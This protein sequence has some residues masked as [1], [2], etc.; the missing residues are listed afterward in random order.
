MKH[1][2]DHHLEAIWKGAMILTVAGIL[3]KVLSAAYRVP[4]QNI[5]GDVGFYIYQQVYPFYG[6]AI[7]L[8]TYGFPVVISKLIAEHP[9]VNKTEAAKKIGTI[10]FV[11][12]LFLGGLLFLVLYFGADAMAGMMGDS[13]LTQLIGIV[14]FS[15]LLMP[16]LSV[17]RG[18]FQGRG[19]MTPTAV[20]QVSEQLIRVCTILVLSYLLVKQGHSLYEVGAGA[21]VGSVGGGLAAVA[22]LFFFYQRHQAMVK[23]QKNPPVFFSTGSIVK[24]LVLQGFTICISSLLLVLFQMVDSF[25]VY[26]YL[27]ENGSSPD[28]AKLL[29]GI[30]DRGQPLIQ[31]GTVVATAFSLSLVPY[32]TRA[33]THGSLSEMKDKMMISIRVSIAIGAAA[34]VGLAWLIRPVNTMLFSNGNGSGVLLVLGFSILFCSI[35]LT[36][37]A[38]LQGLGHA[39]LPAFYVLAGVLVKILLNVAFI[40]GFQTMGAALS[41]LLASF[42]VASGLLLEIKRK[43][44]ITI[45]EKAY[46]YP[47]LVSIALMSATLAVFLEGSLALVGSSRLLASAQSLIGVMLGGIVFL[48]VLIK[49]N[50]FT[51]TE[52]SFLPLGKKL[53][54]LIK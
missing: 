9:E 40:P 53:S 50:Y 46:I 16:F 8:S 42:V 20:S 3:V 31:L 22:V 10:S 38:I 28:E 6:I 25:S 5:V 26:A 14:A 37:S 4:F 18:M 15:F 23:H 24:A 29:K 33:K 2:T 34:S 12:L 30:Y 49:N 43:T 41:T 51:K 1:Q 35:A 39:Y 44:G 54:K 17:G 47:L 21:M 13:E 27:V 45:M 52:L 19:E 11:F 36:A 7:I 48:F 32:I